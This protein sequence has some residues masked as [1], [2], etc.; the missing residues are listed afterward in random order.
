M[1]QA[2]HKGVEIELELHQRTQGFWR[3][4]YTLITHPER[5]RTTHRGEKDFPSMDLA[6]ESALGDARLAIDR[7]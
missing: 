7:G 2:V 1:I 3:C 5:I 6:T 4:D